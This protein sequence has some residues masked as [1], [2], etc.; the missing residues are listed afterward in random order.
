MTNTEQSHRNKSMQ[1]TLK[2]PAFAGLQRTIDGYIH[3]VTEVKTG[4]GTLN[5]IPSRLDTLK[6]K[7]NEAEILTGFDQLIINFNNDK[8]ISV[9]THNNGDP[10]GGKAWRHLAHELAIFLYGDDM[11]KDSSF[12]RDQRREFDLFSRNVIEQIDKLVEITKVK[13]LSLAT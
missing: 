7:D 5:S 2:R 9:T 11:I 12:C 4:R 13:S 10:V 8:H 6:F 1:I 3:L